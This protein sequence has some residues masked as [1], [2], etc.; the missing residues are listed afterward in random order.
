MRK[1]LIYFL[2]TLMIAACTRKPRDPH[3]HKDTCAHCRMT[4][5]DP[6]FA[7]QILA[8][9]GPIYYD[10]LGCAL[11]ARRANP[12][13]NKH[14][15]MVRPDGRESWVKAEEAHYNQGLRTPM[16]YGFGAV[17]AGGTLSFVDVQSRFGAKHE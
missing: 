15:L 4:L 13:L 16:G 6:R 9:Q 11:E 2:M 14:P 10:D 17:S 12:E 5:S 7:A 3:W 8:P 1:A